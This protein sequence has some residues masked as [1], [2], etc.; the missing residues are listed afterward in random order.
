[1]PRYQ[2]VLRDETNCEFV[3]TIDAHDMGDAYDQLHD[4][5]PES[6]VTSVQTEEQVEADR[7]QLYRD[8]ENG[9]DWDDNGRPFYPYD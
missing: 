2:A 9:M 3:V 4:D 7:N 5:Y 6:R 1:M 8:I